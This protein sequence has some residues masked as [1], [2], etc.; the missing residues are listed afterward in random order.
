MPDPPALS[1]C[2]GPCLHSQAQRPS[3]LGLAPASCCGVTSSD[4]KDRDCC[5]P[6]P[7]ACAC[8]HRHRGH[9]GSASFLFAPSALPPGLRSPK[10]SPSP[11][12]PSKIAFPEF[13]AACSTYLELRVSCPVLGFSRNPAPVLVVILFNW[14]LQKK[15]GLLSLT[16]A[17]RPAPYHSNAFLLVTLTCELR[18]IRLHFFICPVT[19]PSVVLLN[20]SFS[21]GTTEVPRADAL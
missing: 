8:A 12:D 21:D 15:Q 6:V 7:L 10:P 2:A 5:S 3:L 11:P 16:P 9:P 20:P 13:H 14:F 4:V 1:V 19:A 17:D 18:Q